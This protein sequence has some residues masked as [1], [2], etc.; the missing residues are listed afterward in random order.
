[1]FEGEEIDTGSGKQ[2]QEAE[3]GLGKKVESVIRDRAREHTHQSV[4]LAIGQHRS[5][6]PLG[7]TGASIPKQTE[8]T[9]QTKQSAQ[10]AV[11]DGQR[12]EHDGP[13]ADGWEADPFV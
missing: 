13:K 6:R 5:A 2:E 9:K 3:S 8:Q 10:A 4:L 7:I 11:E 12:G 1:V